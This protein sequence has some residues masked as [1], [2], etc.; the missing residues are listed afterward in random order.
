M[1]T[2]LEELGEELKSFSWSASN[3]YNDL[4]GIVDN[5]TEIRL[6]IKILEGA[7]KKKRSEITQREIKFF[8]DTVEKIN[9]YFVNQ[10]QKIES[11]LTTYE[12]MLEHIECMGKL[13]DDSQAS[14]EL[15]S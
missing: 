10:S 3:I 5:V 15:W 1:K 13:H 7:N 8:K 9:D 11:L 12:F 2:S 6:G 4:E 14:I